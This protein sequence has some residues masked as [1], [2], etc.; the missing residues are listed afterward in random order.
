MRELDVRVTALEARL[1]DL[2]PLRL[3]VFDALTAGMTPEQITAVIAR[4]V[5]AHR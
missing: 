4:V 1:G 3:A 5:E 2:E